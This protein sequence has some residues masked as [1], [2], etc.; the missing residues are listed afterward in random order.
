MSNVNKDR[1]NIM[2]YQL[3]YFYLF[4][5]D[6]I[7]NSIIEKISGKNMDSPDLLEVI[8]KQV[9]QEVSHRSS[10][11]GSFLDLDSSSIFFGEDRSDYQIRGI[12]QLM[13]LTLQNN[14]I[15]NAFFH[16]LACNSSSITITGKNEPSIKHSITDMI[17]GHHRKNLPGEVRSQFF[18]S[19]KKILN[20]NKDSY[21]AAIINDMNN[22]NGGATD[23]FHISALQYLAP[24]ANF[25]FTEDSCTKFSTSL[26]NNKYVIDNYNKVWNTFQEQQ[27]NYSTNMDKLI[28]ESEINAVFGFSFFYS[29]LKY[30]NKIHSINLSEEKTLKDLEGQPFFEIILQASNLP[31]FFNKEVF[32]KYTCYAFLNS[33][34]LDY[35]YFEESANSVMTRSATLLPKQQQILNCLN[36]MRRFFQIL[37]TITIPLLYSLWEVV[38]NELSQKHN[39]FSV[40]MDVYENYLSYNYASINYNYFNFPDN[41]LCEWGHPKFT[42]DHYLDNQLL[43]GYIKESPYQYVEKISDG[44]K[45]KCILSPNNKYTAEVITWLIKSY[46]NINTLEEQRFPFFF[47]PKKELMN[48][49]PLTKFITQLLDT[50][51]STG[52]TLP[53]K[54]AFFISHRNALYEYLFAK[55]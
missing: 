19:R 49:S 11:Y 51:T 30:V 22:D 24:T 14:C 10:R 16:E 9:F 42:L 1:F 28:F 6:Q 25:L 5:V 4:N 44:R 20:S 15:L 2:K 39:Q 48:Y 8:F 35:S 27:N 36:L 12:F 53:A 54:E 46:C 55:R 40:I 3:Q 23:K 18:D 13:Y 52:G 33:R 34:N 26:K 21:A 29:I 32:L 17:H 47:L 31:L 41:L 43:D 50:Q 7:V 45:V 37:N 38:I